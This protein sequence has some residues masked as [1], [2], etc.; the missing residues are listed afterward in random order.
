[1]KRDVVDVEDADVAMAVNVAAA[2]DLADVEGG[3]NDD[4]V[5]IV[6]AELSF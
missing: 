1:M 3:G 5:T 2:V 4:D 6:A